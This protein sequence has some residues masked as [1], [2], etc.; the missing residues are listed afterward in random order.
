M[1]DKQ[2][3]KVYSKEEVAKHT[4]PE[5]LWMVISGRVYNLTPFLEE[6]PG[7]DGVLMDNAGTR[8]PFHHRKRSYGTLRLTDISSRARCYLCF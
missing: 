2:P 3:P 7:G 5:D 4:E 6:H 1:S 8:L